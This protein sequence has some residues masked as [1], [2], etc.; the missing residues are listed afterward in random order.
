MPADSDLNRTRTSLQRILVASMAL[1]E[2]LLAL[3]QTGWNTTS[4]RST[5][6]MAFCRAA[7]EHAVAQRLLI[8]A[9]LS[10]TALSLVRL[11]FE[12]LVRA[13]WV[14]HAAKE[15]WLD[16]FTSPVPPGDTSE[17]QM[18]PPIPAMIDA[19]EAAA[20][21]S[22]KELRRLHGTIKV[23]HSFVHGGVHMVAHALQGYPEEK[24]MAVMQNRNLMS[25]MLANVI[26]IGS[27]DPRI[28]GSVQRLS[29]VHSACMPPAHA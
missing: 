2:D 29:A 4:R 13:A 10:G 1:D 16:K 14:L 3:L 21:P 6:S 28:V 9:G 17:P 20:G 23:M 25:L 7:L 24:L 8:D 26:V 5:V 12:S 18:G 19:I 15:D 22:A 11:Q 27:Q